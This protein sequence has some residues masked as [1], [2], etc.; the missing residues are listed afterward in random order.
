MRTKRW[1]DSRGE[2]QRS[3]LALAAPALVLAMATGC[4]KSQEAV[5]ADDAGADPSAASASPDPDAGT[6]VAAPPP[7]VSG[8]PDVPVNEGIVG[9]QQLPS[10]YFADQAPPAPPVEDRPAAPAATNVWVPGYWW[11]SRTT[12]H[13]VWVP[14]G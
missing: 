12:S 5:T 10:D 4:R 11:W 14:G 3:L 6:E 1:L 2:W 13:Y 9:T 7:V 8:D